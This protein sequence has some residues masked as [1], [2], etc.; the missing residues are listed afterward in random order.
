MASCSCAISTLLV[1]DDDYFVLLNIRVC[2]S[3]NLFILLIISV[4]PRDGF[5]SQIYMKLLT[6]FFSQTD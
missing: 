6:L 3:E 4:G 1:L 2:E 5:D